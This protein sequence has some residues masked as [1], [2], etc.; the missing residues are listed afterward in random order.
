[1]KLRCKFFFPLMQY[2]LLII[3]TII[4]NEKL[5]GNYFH[6]SA[7]QISSEIIAS[8]ES[9]VNLKMYIIIIIYS[10]NYSEA[11]LKLRKSGLGSN[12]KIKVLDSIISNAGYK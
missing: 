5:I 10:N 3:I 2:G 6:R 9:L 4:I 7:S 1:M 12:S 11:A 8:Q